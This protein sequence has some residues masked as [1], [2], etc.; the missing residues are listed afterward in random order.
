M[1][2]KIIIVGLGIAVSLIAGVI[3]GIWRCSQQNWGP[4]YLRQQLNSWRRQMTRQNAE[5]RIGKVTTFPTP[6]EGGTAT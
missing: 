2:R 5:Q 6:P 3:M 4:R 1:L